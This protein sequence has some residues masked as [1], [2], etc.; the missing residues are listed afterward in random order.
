MA[1]II[2]IIIKGESGYGPVDEAY[3]DKV[4]IDHDSIRYEYK[5]VVEN[6]INTPRKW[7]YMTSSPIFQKM[8]YN[9]GDIAFIVESSRFIREVRGVKIAGGFAK[10]RFVDSDGGIKLRVSRL[11]P[12]KEAA[13]ASLPKKTK[14]RSQ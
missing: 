13:E 5:P 7:S 6:K 3:S 4:I 2:R 9:P 12:T 1:D 8:K 11:F 14:L 10:V